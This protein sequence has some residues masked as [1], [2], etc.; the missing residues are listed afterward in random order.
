MKKLAIVTTHPIQYNAPLFKI[1]QERK[2]IELKVFYT[3]GSTVLENKYDPGF[4]KNVAWDIPLLDGYD[5]E[6]LE[7]ISTHKG[8][9]HFKGIINPAIIERIESYNPDAVLV[10]GW[11]FASHLK[12]IR[13]F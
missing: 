2:I 7:N 9:H 6:F 10:F 1:L 12:V 11:S 3:W 4:K 5:Y 8:S 13:Y